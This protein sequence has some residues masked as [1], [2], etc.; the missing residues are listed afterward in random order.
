[1]SYS[2]LALVI[3]ALNPTQE[4]LHLLG[5]LD[6]W[7]GPIVVIN[8]GS[9]KSAQPV[10]SEASS[11]GAIVLQHKVNK[12]KGAALKTALAYCLNNYPLLIGCVTADADGQHTV[13]DIL[14]VAGRLISSPTELIL[15]CRDFSQK[16]IPLRSFL[17]NRSMSLLFR[18]CGLSISDTQTGL[19]GI[20][21]S[22][23]ETLISVPGERYEYETNML[24]AAHRRRVSFV[25]VP[26][27]TIYIENNGTS[28]FQPFK[29]TLRIISPLLRFALSSLASSLVDLVAFSAI[30]Q[31]PL[32]NHASLIW[33][34]TVIARFL[35]ACFN[36]IC[37]SQLVFSVQ[38]KH[39]S[40]KKY[41]ILCIIQAILSAVMVSSLAS[42]I[43]ISALILKVIVDTILFFVSFFLQRFWVFAARNDVAKNGRSKK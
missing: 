21:S 1:M 16:D 39:G 29:D 34:A 26:I 38:K 32:F 36:Y 4:L 25:E 27:Q 14:R 19:R 20:P 42:F 2:N 24:F 3:P 6:E 7:D 33:F 11:L 15:G 18:M 23:W 5:N 35:S 31:L 40:L 10:F 43:R 30:M 12:G 9:A 17:G 37:N 8:D 13:S 28:H 41:T 22:L